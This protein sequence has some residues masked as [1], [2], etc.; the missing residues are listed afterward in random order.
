MSTSGRAPSVAIAAGGTGGHIF[1]GLAVAD[2]L[3]RARPDV[4][5]VFVGTRRGLESRLIPEAGHRLAL[6]D[7]VPFAGRSRARLPYAFPRATWRS[8]WAGM[9][10]SRWS[11]PPAPPRCRR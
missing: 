10:A 6:V 5:I 1:P 11:W 2:A 7:M 3:V 4:R 8:A 9:P